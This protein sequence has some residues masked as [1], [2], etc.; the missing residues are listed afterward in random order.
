MRHRRDE[1][2]AEECGIDSAAPI[3]PQ[4]TGDPLRDGKPALLLR[5]LSMMLRMLF[6]LVMARAGALAWKT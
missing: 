6:V 3:M 1:E 5:I 4:R 2:N